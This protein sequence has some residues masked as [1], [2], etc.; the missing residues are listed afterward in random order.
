VEVL[1]LVLVLGVC[2]LFGFILSFLMSFE[3]GAWDGGEWREGKERKGGGMS[4]M[5]A[6][7]LYS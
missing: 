7:I 2:G 3:L 5:V 4:G 1:V 6:V